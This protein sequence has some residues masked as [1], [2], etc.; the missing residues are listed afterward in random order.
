MP[1]S[2]KKQSNSLQN[3]IKFLLNANIDNS[4]EI[5]ELQLLIRDNIKL[6]K[7]DEKKLDKKMDKLIEKISNNVELLKKMSQLNEK[8]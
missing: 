5:V 3:L 2:N 6:K 4:V 7:K 8:K 1:N